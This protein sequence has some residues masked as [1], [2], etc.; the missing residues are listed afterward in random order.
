MTYQATSMPPFIKL[1]GEVECKLPKA[2][3]IDDL[4]FNTRRTY[5]IFNNATGRKLRLSFDPKVN[6]TLHIIYTRNTNK[7]TVA[8]GESQVCD[9]PEYVDAVKAWMSYEIEF[10]DKTPT[11]DYAKNDYDRQIQN[12]IASLAQAVN[13]EDNDIEPDTSFDEDHL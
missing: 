11:V 6:G 2:K 1:E 5:K 3:N 4:K 13:D 12:L 8:G 7:F 9:I 10:N